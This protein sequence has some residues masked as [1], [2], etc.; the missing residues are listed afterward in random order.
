MYFLLA[1]SYFPENT[2]TAKNSNFS[3]QLRFDGRYH[4]YSYYNNEVI[5]T[6]IIA[7]VSPPACIQW[8]L[9]S[10]YQ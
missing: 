10:S 2:A 7:V 9:I 6:S 8:K 4:C 5:Q 3:D 1:G